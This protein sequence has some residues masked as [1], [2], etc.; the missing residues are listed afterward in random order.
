[1]YENVC[2]AISKRKQ[3]NQKS[4]MAKKSNKIGVKNEAVRTLIF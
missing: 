2:K 1:M 4:Q 3:R